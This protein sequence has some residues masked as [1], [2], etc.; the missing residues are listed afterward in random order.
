MKRKGKRKTQ[1]KGKKI[2]E[3]Q[4]KGKTT[5]QVKL[6]ALARPLGEPVKTPKA[7]FG[8]PSG[9]ANAPSLN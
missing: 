9:R 5:S 3:N 8:S 7:N 4:R 6:G 1:R 2:T